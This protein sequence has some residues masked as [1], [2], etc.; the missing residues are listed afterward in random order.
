MQRLFSLA[1][2]AELAAFHSNFARKY[3]TFNDGQ[4]PPASSTQI[5]EVAP[6]FRRIDVDAIS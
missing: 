3:G 2:N 1:N 6:G 4:V 5:P